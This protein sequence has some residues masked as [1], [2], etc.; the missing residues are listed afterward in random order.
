MKKN[1]LNVFALSIVVFMLSALAFAQ[2]NRSV[3]TVGNLYV[4]SANAGGVNYVE[5][6]VSVTQNNGRNGYLLK[7]D[8]LEIGEKVITGAD[9]KAEI[10]LN[11]GS[12]LR[13]SENSSFEFATTSL[14]DLQLKLNR[15]S[16]MFEV[17]TDNDFTFAVNTPKGRFYII[18]SGV[19]RVDVLGD[20]SGKIAVWRGKAQ[21]GDTNATVIKGGRA[22][23]VNGSQVAVEKF[24]RDKKDALETWSKTRAKELAKV[25][26]RLVRND[27]RNTLVNSFNRRGWS[28]YDSYGLWVLDGFSGS[29][30]F[31][32]FGYGWN[33]PYGYG[34]GRDIWYLRLP[35]V[36]YNQPPPSYQ[37]T[38]TGVLNSGVTGRLRNN[39]S[40]NGEP[41]IPPFEKVQR[42]IGRFPTEQQDTPN[43][44]RDSPRFPTSAPMQQQSSPVLNSPTTA[45]VRKGDN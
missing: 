43:I 37:Q 36:I 25:N 17:I 28:L 38:Q 12:Y 8:R 24:D 35:R 23:T 1:F 34:F 44:Y 10:L 45:P 31:L 21:V 27:L 3:S 2:D 30:C 39:N 7:G 29:Y 19:Y 41:M 33:S 13:L 6:K 32:P 16:A 11:P 42:D 26:S 20:G 9:G 22:A 4:I 15:G 14:D 40:T 18:Q 5:G